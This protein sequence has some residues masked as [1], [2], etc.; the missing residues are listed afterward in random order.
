M[1]VN[2]LLGGQ[3]PIAANVFACQDVI[4]NMGFVTDHLSAN[5]DPDGVGCIVT[6][7]SISIQ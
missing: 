4:L 3:E 6:N 1:C 5:A 7:V 2:V